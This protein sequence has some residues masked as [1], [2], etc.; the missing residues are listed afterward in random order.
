MQPEMAAARVSLLRD[1]EQHPVT[2]GLYVRVH[3]KNLVVGREEPW[4]SE[5]E[6][7]RDDRVRL[8]RHNSHNYS[9][10]V[11]RHT[12]RWETTPFQGTISEMVDVMRSIMQHLVAPWG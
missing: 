8:T 11:K 5:G 6:M 7:I 2:S 10:S 1:L 3:G 12:G 4:G 9:L